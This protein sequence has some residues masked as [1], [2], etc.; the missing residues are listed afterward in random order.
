MKTDTI[1]FYIYIYILYIPNYNL[2][3]AA[4]RPHQGRRYGEGLEEKEKILISGMKNVFLKT[5]VNTKQHFHPS[6]VQ[7]EDVG[8]CCQPSKINGTTG[9]RLGLGKMKL[10]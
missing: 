1:N 9:V 4:R 8:F 10:C 3:M 2:S 6:P 7:T 5:R